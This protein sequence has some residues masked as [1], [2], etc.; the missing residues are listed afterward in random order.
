MRVRVLGLLLDGVEAWVGRCMTT[1]MDYN[2]MFEWEVAHDIGRL[3]LE[4]P[5]HCE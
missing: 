4:L 3:R 5:L 2:D 1:V